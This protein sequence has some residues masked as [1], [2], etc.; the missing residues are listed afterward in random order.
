MLALLAAATFVFGGLAAWSGT[1]A[2]NL[3]AAPSARNLALADPGETSQ[4]SRQMT[5]A[6]DALFSYNYASPASTDK[7]AS[8]LLTGPAVKQ[9]AAMF[10]S[11]KQKAP[12]EKLVLTLTVSSVG[13]ELLTSDTAR[14]LVF[15]TESD[16]S[17]G[18]SAPTV[19]G[20]MLAVNAVRVGGAW[21]IEGIDTFA[22]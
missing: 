17:A 6:I 5:S 19:T 16:G 8:R 22:G 1:E 20:A 3:A 12:K 13:V 2:G 4:V 10:T 9:Y 7:A 11:V 18:D 14:V 15:G 21:K